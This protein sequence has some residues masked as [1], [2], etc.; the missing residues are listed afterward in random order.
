MNVKITLAS[1]INTINR[2]RE[3]DRAR[4]GEEREKEKESENDSRRVKEWEE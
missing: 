1:E 2:G 4:V 3:K